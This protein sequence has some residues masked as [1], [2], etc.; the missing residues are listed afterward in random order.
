MVYCLIWSFIWLLATIKIKSTLSVFNWSSDRSYNCKLGGGEFNRK[1]AR[2]IGV[3]RPLLYSSWNCVGSVSAKQSSEHLGWAKFKIR[4]IHEIVQLTPP[5]T[6]QLLR[7]GIILRW[8][9]SKVYYVRGGWLTWQAISQILNFIFPVTLD[10]FATE[11]H[12]LL[13]HLIRYGFL[14]SRL[15]ERVQSRTRSD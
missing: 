8:S 1:M 7:R 13:I 10:L 15:I 3:L 11:T 4:R 14:I 2:V 9:I 5:Y 12:T 6:S